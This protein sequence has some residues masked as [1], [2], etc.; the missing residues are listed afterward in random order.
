MKRFIL[1]WCCGYNN[2]FRFDNNRYNKHSI[3]LDDN[4]SGSF[5]KYIYELGKYP[6][7]KYGDKQTSGNGSI[8]RNAAI[9]ICYFRDE[10]K[11]LKKAKSQS[12]ITHQG[13]EA[14]G[15]C[16]LITFIIIKILRSKFSQYKVNLKN[17]LNDLKDFIFEYESVNYLANSKQ[18]GND[19]DR[20]LNWKDKNF[21]YS[22]YRSKLHPDYIGSYCMDVLA[23]ALH[24]LYNK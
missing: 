4:I 2:S 15:C 19:K 20:N 5:M 23:M 14:A 12:L 1:W 21:K 3:G 7:T 6:Y 11:A 8:M 16:I 18:E 9:P 10:Y 17:L 24:I 22:E 13:D